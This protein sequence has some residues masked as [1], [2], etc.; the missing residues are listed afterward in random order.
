MKKEQEKI[1]VAQATTVAA[2][3]TTN[4]RLDA[5]TNKID[6]LTVVVA[7]IVKMVKMFKTVKMSGRISYIITRENF[8][9]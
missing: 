8:R 7:D 2:L 5:Q 9:S 3:Q 1:E 6:D 4:D